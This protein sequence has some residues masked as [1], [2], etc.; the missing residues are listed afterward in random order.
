MGPS[1]G[2]LI[3]KEIDGS[4]A[5]IRERT[6]RQ[7]SRPEKEE[8]GFRSSQENRFGNPSPMVMNTQAQLQRAAREL[9]EGTFIE[10]A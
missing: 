8:S 1:F 5:L 4:E 9:R 6:T 2:I 10:S 3:E 7:R